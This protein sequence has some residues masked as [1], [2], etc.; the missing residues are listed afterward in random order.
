MPKKK[1]QRKFSVV[2]NIMRSIAYDLFAI[3]PPEGVDFNINTLAVDVVTETRIRINYLV[4]I[5]YGETAAIRV[6]GE[7]HVD[8]DDANKV[9]SLWEKGE[10]DEFYDNAIVQSIYL[11]VSPVV[12]T[13]SSVLGFPPALIPPII[14]AGEKKKTTKKRV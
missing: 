3:E 7:L 4:K 2:G 6:K 13:L 8:V 12:V 11:I 9:R 14:T 1:E 5:S 10:L